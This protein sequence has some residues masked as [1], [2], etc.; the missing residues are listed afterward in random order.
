ML[1]SALGSAIIATG[2]DGLGWKTDMLVASVGERRDKTDETVCLP[3]GGQLSVQRQRDRDASRP[4]ADGEA[5][6]R[7]CARGGICFD[8]RAVGGMS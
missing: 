7:R 6:H 8:H 1:T 3:M 5:V 4:H 2:S